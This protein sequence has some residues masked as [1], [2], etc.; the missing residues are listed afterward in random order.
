MYLP[1]TAHPHH[2]VHHETYG[3]ARRA[4]QLHHLRFLLLRLVVR[5]V[6]LRHADTRAREIPDR[7]DERIVVCVQ[8]SLV[9]LER[10][11]SPLLHPVS[12]MCHTPLTTNRS[13]AVAAQPDNQGDEH[14]QPHRAAH[15]ADPDKGE[16]SVQLAA[17][18]L[19]DLLD[20]VC[21]PLAWSSLLDK[22]QTKRL[23]VK[24]FEL[25]YIK[26]RIEVSTHRAVLIGE[27]GGVYPRG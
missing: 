18:V 25:G 1:T 5:I 7:I 9:G 23:W 14:D 2:A 20:D 16:L 6:I 12:F 22:R 10:D 11:A 27:D 3:L 19:E 24:T 4:A 21:M 26:E 15:E 13:P 17:D 8:C